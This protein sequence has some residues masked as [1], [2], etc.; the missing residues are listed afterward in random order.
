MRIRSNHVRMN[1]R[2]THS[3]TA[4]RYRTGKGGIA[5]DRIG[6][7]NLFKMKIGKPGNQPRNI[8]AGRVHLDGNG[9]RV[10]VIFHEKDQRQAEVRG[11]IHRLPE[12]SFAGSTVAD[13]NVSDL[14]AV[15]G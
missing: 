5:D 1:K 2:R 3:G 4:M 13:R 14:V 6:A 9:D 15:E 8:A 12:L 11:G 7:V 10:A